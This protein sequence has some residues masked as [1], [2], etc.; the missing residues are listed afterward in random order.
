MAAPAPQL[1]RRRVLAFATL[2]ALTLF[3]LTSFASPRVRAL[4]ED[5]VRHIGGLTVRET[6]LYPFTDDDPLLEPSEHLTPEKAC[7]AVEFEFDL[8]T[9]LPDRY[10]LMNEVIVTTGF[11]SVH[12]RWRGQETRGDGLS[13]HVSPAASDVEYLVGN[14]SLEQ[15]EINGQ[16]ALFIHGGW[17]ENTKSWDPNINREVRWVQNGLS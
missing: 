3:I 5:V 13:L 9:A 2:A 11:R 4:V 1:R 15:I 7:Q 16:K 6:A 8:P 17:L 12:I 10:L 14:G